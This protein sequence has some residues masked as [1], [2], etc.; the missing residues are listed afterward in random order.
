[1]W[2]VVLASTVAAAVLL[3]P[4]AAWADQSATSSNDND[5]IVV[6]RRAP[7]LR[8]A[9]GADAIVGFAGPPQSGAYRYGYPA[10][11]SGVVAGGGF[12]VDAGVELG[13]G[14]AVYLRLQAADFGPKPF[15][16]EAAGYA[17]AEWIP[18]RWLSVASGLGYELLAPPN[19]FNCPTGPGAAAECASIARAD[20]PHW[21][22][23][24]LPLVLGFNVLEVRVPD[25][26][27]RAAVRVTLE[28][29]GGVS[30]AT[31]AYGW[32]AGANLAFALM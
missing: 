9:L 6:A 26:G 27:T 5:A 11:L 10:S 30:L 25:R 22:G 19:V 1:V 14:A 20:Y 23:V 32:H 4:E 17:M 24:S 7:R 8:L 15:A 12:T 13:D 31:F 18:L 3:G 16:T 28:G 29:A 21:S 2:R